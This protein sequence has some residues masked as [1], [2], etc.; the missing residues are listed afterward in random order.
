VVIIEYVIFGPFSFY[1]EHD[2]GDSV[3][4]A[5]M[6]MSHEYPLVPNLYSYGA[7]GKDFFSDGMF[8]ELGLYLFSFLPSWF[9]LQLLTVA[10]ILLMGWYTY[11]LCLDYFGVKKIWAVFAAV[12]AANISAYG[13][14]YNYSL[15]LLPATIWF[16]ASLSERDYKRKEL[17]FGLV[18]VMLVHSY[19]GHWTFIVTVIPPVIVVW[20]LVFKPKYL[21]IGWFAGFVSVFFPIIIRW[22]DLYAILQNA[23]DSFRPEFII[24]TI[25]V[26]DFFLGSDYNYLFYSLMLLMSFVMAIYARLNVL[27]YGVSSVANFHKMLV[28]ALFF[29][30]LPL[31]VMVVKPY[32][33]NLVPVVEGFS[34]FRFSTSKYYLTLLVFSLGCSALYEIAGKRIKSILI[35]SC[36]LMLLLFVVLLKIEHIE[37][38]VRSGSF[39]HAFHSKTLAELS[40]D[41][42]ND[43]YYRAE[44]VRVLPSRLNAYGIETLGGNFNVYPSRFHDYWM[45]LVYPMRYSAPDIFNKQLYY[46][47]GL[48][49]NFSN[50]RPVDNIS[51]YIDVDL[52][53]LGNV[54]YVVSKNKI[55]HPDL[56]EVRSAPIPWD[57]LSILQKAIKNIKSS[58]IGFDDYY[59]YE[60]MKV[61]PRFFVPKRL[62][63]FHDRDDL[64]HELTLK[65][66]E[67]L[68]ENALVIESEIQA[69]IDDLYS[70]AHREQS[71]GDVLDVRQLTDAYCISVDFLKSGILASSVGYNKNWRGEF[72]LDDSN[73]ISLDVF[74]VYNAFL[75]VIV[76]EG[77]GQIRLIYDPPYS[78]L[79]LDCN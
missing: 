47:N 7:G 65:G 53:S 77:K 14:L 66:V 31:V 35:Y 34:F 11:K 58:F 23:Q 2:N 20:L 27:S 70:I 74:P 43:G 59:I 40:S 8:G 54:K 64:L 15:S 69:D 63:V 1:M 18:T 4:P 22:K 24:D 12:W 75:G 41:L 9:A 50:R 38:Y 36:S 37:S 6:V 3:I 71:P 10:M 17:W 28:L 56:I 79:Q 42:K 21:M 16:I 19:I 13:Q 68:S 55:N 62:S 57:S 5:L 32:V 25:T 39:V 33:V 78:S 30:I 76:P 67:Y 48:H 60:N 49:I 29:M 72:I 61:L 45:R 26:T 46:G 52:L 73:V 44:P 51:D